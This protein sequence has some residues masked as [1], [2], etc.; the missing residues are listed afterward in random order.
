MRK[1]GWIMTAAVAVL[2]TGGVVSGLAGNEATPAV[3]ATTNVVKHQTMCPVMGGEVD[4]KF[5]A[6]YQGQRVYFCCNACPAMFKKDPAKY[7]K[8]LEAEG[9]TLDKTPRAATTNAPAAVPPQGE[10]EQTAD[11]HSGHHH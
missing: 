3:P 7:I 6:D 9:I 8:K 1:T 4:K 2:V 11:E 5:F 10:K